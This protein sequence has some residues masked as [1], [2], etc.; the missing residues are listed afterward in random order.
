MT[1]LNSAVVLETA[2]GSYAVDEVLG[3]GGAGRVYGGKSAE[4]NAVAVK[5]LSKESAS[6]DK[7]ARF[8]REIAFLSRNRHPN[9]V[10]VS[11]Y[12]VAQDKSICGPFYVMPR[13]GSSLRKTM[14]A[15]I[16]PNSV[17]NI[18]EKILDGVEAAHLQ[19]VVHRDLKPENVLTDP[20]SGLVA[21][22]DFGIA[23]FTEQLLVTSVETGPTQR[24]ANF[25]YA[26]P[27]QRLVGRTATKAADIYAL[28]LMLNEMFTGQIP[29]GTDF[30]TIAQSQ[31]SFGYLDH[32][33]AQMLRQNP[34]DR[35]AS[36]DAV[37]DLLQR[38]LTTEISRQRLNSIKNEVVKVGDIDDDL[39]FTPPKIVAANWDGGWLR[40]TLDRPV[41]QGWVSALQNMGS[42]ESV[43]NR[44]PGAFI[45]DG[46]IARVPSDADD[47]Q[48][49]IDC[50]KSWLPRAS[51][52][53]K[54]DLEAKARADA[55][56]RQRE[57]ALQKAREESLLKVN[58]SL[59]F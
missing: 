26:A 5:V 8:K 44:G 27:E 17:L 16:N 57:L 42:Y 36:V 23:S 56:K 40:L 38:S 21:I 15:G 39:A 32:T 28:G 9:I 50:F 7:R 20:T 3:E 13:F 35:P 52:R 53:L 45:F 24:L 2:F 37:K 19:G 51:A 55:E 46:N 41:H 48:R 43:W 10:T 22:A 59:K 34:D 18:F 47:V 25:Q 54:S 49:I 1:K 12:G 30:R 11:D 33:V 14:V 31:S 58:S 4:G 6:K 29:H